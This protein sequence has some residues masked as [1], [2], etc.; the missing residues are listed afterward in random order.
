MPGHERVIVEN[1]HAFVASRFERQTTID[2]ADD[3][4][5]AGLASEIHDTVTG[6]TR[7]CN[8]E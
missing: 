2:R 6:M 1:V 8:F 5:L 7:S 4:R 3:L